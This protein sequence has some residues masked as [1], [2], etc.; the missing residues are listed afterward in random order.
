[1][2]ALTSRAPSNRRCR[3]RSHVLDLH[4]KV[5]AAIRRAWRRIT[6]RDGY[7]TASHRR[8]IAADDEA[9]RFSQHVESHFEAEFATPSSVPWNSQRRLR[10][11]PAVVPR[12]APSLTCHGECEGAGSRSWPHVAGR[13]PWRTHP[14]G[15]RRPPHRARRLDGAR[16]RSRPVGSERAIFTGHPEDVGALVGPR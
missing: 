4:C 10:P 7:R 3:C 2:P 12:R 13:R 1:M 9:F 8:T 15:Q 6:R 5:F 14:A 16:F 11:G